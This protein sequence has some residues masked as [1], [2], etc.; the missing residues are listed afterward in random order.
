MKIMS[1]NALVIVTL[2]TMDIIINNC[3]LRFYN[4][5]QKIPEC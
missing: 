1:A 4:E 2:N 3:F 5:I